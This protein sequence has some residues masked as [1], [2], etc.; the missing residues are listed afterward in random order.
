MTRLKRALN[1]SKGRNRV[2]FGGSERAVVGS[3]RV[4]DS[5]EEKSSDE[6]IELVTALKGI[7]KPRICLRKG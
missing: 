5:G 1:H 6:R 2:P 7:G 3:S 4:G